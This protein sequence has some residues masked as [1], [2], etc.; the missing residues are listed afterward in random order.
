MHAVIDGDPAPHQPIGQTGKL[1]K[2]C[3]NGGTATNIQG[4]CSIQ[5]T[6]DGSAGIV[7]AR[8][9]L[10]IT[11]ICNRPF[12]LFAMSAVHGLI[13]MDAESISSMAPTFDQISFRVL[14]LPK[15]QR[16][17][18]PPTPSQNQCD[19]QKHDHPPATA[20]KETFARWQPR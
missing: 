14:A 17:S 5:T 2:D 20:V 1:R 19:C 9:K 10:L 6:V 8:R 18:N 4:Q 13:P 12:H 3:N 7:D 15:N 16:W 11:T